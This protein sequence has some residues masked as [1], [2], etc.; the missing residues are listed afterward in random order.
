[1]KS[2]FLTETKGGLIQGHDFG[3]SPRATA[4]FDEIKQALP[5]AE[6]VTLKELKIALGES[7]GADSE[8]IFSKYSSQFKTE[9][10]ASYPEAQ[11]R[12]Y[13]QF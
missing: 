1:M 12:I 5:E 3:A 9:L 10:E 2:F 6:Q 7:K 8:I 4:Y 13:D 11:T